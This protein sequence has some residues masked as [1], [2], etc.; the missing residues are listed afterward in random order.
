MTAHHRYKKKKDISAAQV[1]KDQMKSKAA[2]KKYKD[3]E[4]AA[5]AQ[6]KA[7]VKKAEQ[8]KA[9]ELNAKKAYVQQSSAPFSAA[10]I[11]DKWTAAAKAKAAKEK[12]AAA[13]KGAAAKNAA[14]NKKLGSGPCTCK[15]GSSE[16]YNRKYVGGLNTL[17]KA[18]A[19]CAAD[20]RCKG[21]TLGSSGSDLLLTSGNGPHAS[22]HAHTRMHADTCMH[23]HAHIHAQTQTHMH[24]N[25]QHVC[26]HMHT[27][28]VRAHIG[29]R[30]CP[31]M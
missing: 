19:A 12:A 18:S 27:T 10:P 3:K 31:Y 16:V 26:V 4:K 5:A 25:M 20:S 9:K 17:D 2:A 30:V 13:A 28:R 6:E 14:A 1:A 11:V 24:V 15:A 7:A 21:F 23:M 29:A 22:I 8:E